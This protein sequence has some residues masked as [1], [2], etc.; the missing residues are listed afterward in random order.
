MISWERGWKN[1][2]N[3]KGDVGGQARRAVTALAGVNCTTAIRTR[4]RRIDIRRVV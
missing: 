3:F 4:H 1:V 2:R